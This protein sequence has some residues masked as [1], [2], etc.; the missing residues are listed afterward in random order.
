[1]QS[2]TIL[3]PPSNQVSWAFDDNEAPVLEIMKRSS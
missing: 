2:K 3:V 1:M